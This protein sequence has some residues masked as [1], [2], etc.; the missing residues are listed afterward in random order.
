MLKP[1]VCHCHGPL[2]RLML[3]LRPVPWR[4]AVERAGWCWCRFGDYRKEDPQSFS[5][6]ENMSFYPQFMFNLRRSQFVQA[7]CCPP[8]SAL[9]SINSGSD[10]CW[11][12]TQVTQSLLWGMSIL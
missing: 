3:S 11:R 9:C 10:H 4:L 5:L 7:S 1:L 8:G 12:F 2:L 6:H